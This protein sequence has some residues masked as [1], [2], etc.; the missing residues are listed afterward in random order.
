MASPRREG[1]LAAPVAGQALELR[2]EVVETVPRQGAHAYDAG[3][4][5]AWCAAAQ[6]GL[7]P[8]QECRVRSLRPRGPRAEVFHHFDDD[9]RFRHRAAGAVDALGLDGVVRVPESRRVD[10]ADGQSVQV[11]VRG[12]SV[13]GGAGDG[14]DDRSVLA[15]QPVEYA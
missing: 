2:Y 15:R 1:A 12:Q 3:F 11:E 14:G 4:D 6:V 7:V 10:D 13:P 5:A 8:D 9:V